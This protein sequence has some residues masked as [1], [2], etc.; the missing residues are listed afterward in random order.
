MSK[1]RASWVL[2]SLLVLSMGQT[3]A[4]QAVTPPE[5][6]D[7]VSLGGWWEDQVTDIAVDPNT[8]D[9]IVV[10]NFLYDLHLGPYVL[11]VSYT[12]LTLPT[13]REV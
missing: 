5:W 1:F 11:S 10:G 4:A 12:H 8:G 3:A 7:A 9:I 13:N 6:S 2:V